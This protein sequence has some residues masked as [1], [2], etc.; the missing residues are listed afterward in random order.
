MEKFWNW[1]GSTTYYLRR[2]IKSIKCF[3]VGHD[4]KWG[5]RESYEPDYCAYCWK[6]NPYDMLIFRDY[7]TKIF[8]WI[9][10]HIPEEWGDNLLDWKPFGVK[11]MP[12]WWEY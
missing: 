4:I 6:D 12:S 8:V 10:E 5:C 9:I 11:K 2:H 7:M 1:Y 3:F